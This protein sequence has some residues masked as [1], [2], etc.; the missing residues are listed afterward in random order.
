MRSE[1]KV[2]VA[3]VGSAN[4][5]LVVDVA[6]LPVSG[7]TV[8]GGDLQRIPGGKGANQ[9]VAA[10]RLGRRTA[11]IGRVGGD[12]AGAVL[13]AAVGSAGVDVAGLLTTA[14]AP[15]GIALIPV[16]ADGENV[17]VVSPGANGR[18]S[19]ADVDA[20]AE[21]LEAA[22]VTLLQLE[23]PVEA[24]VTAA[25]RAAGLVVLTPA[26]APSVPLDE[27][28]LSSIDVLVPNQSELATMAGQPQLAASGAVDAETAVELARGIP[29]AAAVVTLGSAGAMVVTPDD[30]RH[31]P[32]PRVASVDTTAAGDAFCG[33]LA[34]ALVDGADLV[35]AAQWAVK[36]G[37]AS[38][39]RH[40]AQSS[41]PA[42]A[43]VEELLEGLL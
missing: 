23:V 32:A 42:R 43:E 25:R 22:A 11:M 38:T 20:A 14:G 15:S 4:L 8:H 31:V 24:V 18:L 40:G 34:D 21:V 2:E 10:A 27:D 7:E 6:S 3:V 17:V 33:A 5:D 19:A 29:A 35:A 12:D 39:M 30:V 1:V 13:R 16:A 36:V 26:P 9:A 37:A 41:L 28:L